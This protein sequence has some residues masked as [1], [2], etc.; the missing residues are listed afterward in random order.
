VNN[1]YLLSEPYEINAYT[2][3]AKMSII[4]LLVVQPAHL[5]LVQLIFLVIPKQHMNISLPLSIFSGL[6][7]T[8]KTAA[9]DFTIIPLENNYPKDIVSSINVT[10]IIQYLLIMVK[11]MVVAVIYV[12]KTVALLM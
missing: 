4:H 9:K 12:S 8:G 3:L 6:T 7:S 1:A 2:D 5:P 11:D 10:K